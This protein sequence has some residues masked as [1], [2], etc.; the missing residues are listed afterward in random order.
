MA[1]GRIILGVHDTMLKVEASRM[2][3]LSTAL[4]GATEKG[5]DNESGVRRRL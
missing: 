4:A 3:S 2:R 1:E 5:T